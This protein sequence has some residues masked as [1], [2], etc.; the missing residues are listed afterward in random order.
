MNKKNTNWMW[1]RREKFGHGG[2]NR[3]Y[4]EQNRQRSRH[5]L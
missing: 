4:S 3:L 2:W 5:C 1:K